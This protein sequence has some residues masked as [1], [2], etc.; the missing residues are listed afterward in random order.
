MALHRS[1]KVKSSKFEI[2]L[3]TKLWNVLQMTLQR[4]DVFFCVYLHG[5]EKYQDFWYVYK[6]IFVLPNGQSVVR[7]KFNG[8]KD[9]LVENLNQ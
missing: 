6:V 9:V 1:S 8:N 2:L 3:Q 5:N 7:R 4:F